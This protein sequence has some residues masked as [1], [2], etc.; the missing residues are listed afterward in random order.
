VN[1]IPS[2]FAIIIGNGK[3]AMGKANAIPSFF[4]VDSN[5]AW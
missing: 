5:M 2:S 3:M 4:F 1:A